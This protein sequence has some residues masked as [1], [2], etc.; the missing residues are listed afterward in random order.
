MYGNNII[1]RRKLEELTHKIDGVEGTMKGPQGEVK[2]IKHLVSTLA[3]WQ[4]DLELR[5][6]CWEK[7]FDVCCEREEV[8][9]SDVV[10]PWVPC[11]VI[12]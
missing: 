3:R 5:I 11:Y 8:E 2:E 10:A 9:K 1:V 7:V 6:A 4:T 12:A